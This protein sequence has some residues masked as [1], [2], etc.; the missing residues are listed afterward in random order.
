[1]LLGP[2]TVMKFMLY[3]CEQAFSYLPS[4][5]SKHRNR[6]LSIENEICVCLFNIRPQIKY[7][8]SKIQAQ[9]SYFFHTL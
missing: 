8:C 6:L 7:L 2:K 4:I 9:V 5:N 1:M 3:M